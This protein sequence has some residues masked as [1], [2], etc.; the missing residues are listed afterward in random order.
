MAG[1][2]VLNLSRNGFDLP[3]RI[4]AISPSFS[5]WIG[6]VTSPAAGPAA[7]LASAARKRHGPVRPANAAPSTARRETTRNIARTAA[8]NPR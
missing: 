2:S 5:A 3:A 1:A 8:L 7:A 4:T 6:A